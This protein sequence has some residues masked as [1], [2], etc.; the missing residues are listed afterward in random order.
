MNFQGCAIL[1]LIIGCLGLSGFV[2]LI[3]YPH[4]HATFQLAGNSSIRSCNHFFSFLQTAHHLNK[5]VVLNACFYFPH[6]YCIARHDKNN[7]L[8]IVQVI[9]FFLFLVIFIFLYLGFIFTGSNSDQGHTKRTVGS[10]GKNIKQRQ[11]CPDGKDN[12]ARL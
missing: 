11:T 1:N 12:D 8:D 3:G 7:F 9:F 6:G 5:V 2:F 4:A 10:I